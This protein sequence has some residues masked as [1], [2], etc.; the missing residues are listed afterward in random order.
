MWGT[1]SMR[2]RFILASL[3]I[4]ITVGTSAGLSAQQQGVGLTVPISG[5]GDLGATFSGTLRISSF[6]VQ[7]NTVAATGVASGVLDDA[8]GTRRNIVTRLSIPVDLTGSLARR[9]TDTMLAVASC[10]TIH[11]EFGTF[12]IQVLGS[13]LALDSTALDITTAG[14]AATAAASQTSQ[15]AV[16][17]SSFDARF[18]TGT[19]T[20]PT[21]VPMT[22]PTFGGTSF[23]STVPG[24]VAVFG[25]QIAGTVT[26]T[27]TSPVAQPEDLGPLLCSA[28]RLRD[29]ATDRAQLVQLLN[30]V[31][32]TIG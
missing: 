23:G 10:D 27:V 1:Y 15:Q 13:T 28:S 29:S 2:T 18:P 21:G 25:S 11:L 14:G 16:P 31:I 20:P 26:P 24:T 4:A 30:R 17:V 6:A 12:A 8:T 22:M 3:V 5:F 19:T 32:A 7:G 9:N